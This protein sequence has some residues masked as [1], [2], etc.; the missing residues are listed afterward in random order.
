MD[1]SLSDIREYSDWFARVEGSEVKPKARKLG[2][3]S[4]LLRVFL[5][6]RILGGRQH[7]MR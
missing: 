2:D 7:E 4:V 3:A 6:W 5:S 1:R